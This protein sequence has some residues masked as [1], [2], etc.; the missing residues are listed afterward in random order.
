LTLVE[1]MSI[2][3]E[4]NNQSIVTFAFVVLGFIAYGITWVLFELLAETF[5]PVAAL[6][7]QELWKNGIPVAVGALVTLIL[8]TGKKSNTVADEAVTE[9]RKVVWPSRKDTI[10]MTT[11]CCV[12]VVIAG[13]G[14]GIFDFLA[15]Q[16]IKVFVK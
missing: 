3:N 14:F 9:L 15:S 1:L 4:N 11:V 2:E 6:R 8:I 16:V 13:I 12:M 10:A 7:S 5:G